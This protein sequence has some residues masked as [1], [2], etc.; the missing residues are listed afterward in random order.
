M[1]LHHDNAPI[2]PGQLLVS[3]FLEPR[4]LSIKALADQIGLT[5]KHLSNIVHGHVRITPATAARLARALG[6][7]PALW[8]NLQ[9]A[10]DILEAEREIRNLAATAS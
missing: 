6:T 9:S 2:P 3:D 10:L 4:R 7:S 5:R 8:I 1:S